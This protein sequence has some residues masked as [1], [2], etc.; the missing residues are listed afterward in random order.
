MKKLFIILLAILGGGCNSTNQNTMITS[1]DTMIANVEAPQKSENYISIDICKCLTE[2]GSSEWST[3]NADA[4]R[5]AISKEIGVENWEKV[6]F[7]QTPELSRKWDALVEKCTGSKEVE[8]GI[9]EIDDNNKL[10]PEIG[11]SYGYIWESINMEAQ[12]YT[13]LAFDGTIF[14]TSAYTMN[15]ETNSE[16]FTKVI[17]ASGKWSALDTQHVEGKYEQNDVIVSWSFNEDYTKLTNN[18]G[19]VFERVRVK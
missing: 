13:T 9:E 6:N 14:R 16:N 5:D 8:T 3:S 7:S 10:I 15:G 17:D 2:P 4:C 1:D 18:K 19:V 12:I 11:T